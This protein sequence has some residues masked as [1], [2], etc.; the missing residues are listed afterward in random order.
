MYILAISLVVS[1]DFSS[2]MPYS[3]LQVHSAT[4]VED[5]GQLSSSPTILQVSSTV[6]DL[7]TSLFRQTIYN[8]IENLLLDPGQPSVEKRNIID[9]AV[10]NYHKQKYSAPTHSNEG[11]HFISS[12]SK[13]TSTGKL[14]DNKSRKKLPHIDDNEKIKI[15]SSQN[16]NANQGVDISTLAGKLTITFIN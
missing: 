5:R 15:L 11:A 4:N 10:Q 6:S 8:R 9:S 3:P 2:A 7:L 12:D 13:G 14:S 16:E 1:V